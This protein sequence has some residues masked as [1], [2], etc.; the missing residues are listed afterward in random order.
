[1]YTTTRSPCTVVPTVYTRADCINKWWINIIFRC[2]RRG[3][4]F[5]CLSHPCKIYVPCIYMYIDGIG[6]DRWIRAHILR[7]LNKRLEF[8]PE[9]THY[10]HT[11]IVQGMN[12]PTHSR[13]HTRA[14]KTKISWT[15][16]ASVLM[17][18]ATSTINDKILLTERRSAHRSLCDAVE[19]LVPFFFFF[20][21]YHFVESI[22]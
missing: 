3:D 5:T 8:E 10:L 14:Q 18:H 1:M 12:G 15:F 7:L 2:D 13:Q 4:A 21:I 16:G 22:L 19:F 17:Q 20:F 9:P 11:F 6:R